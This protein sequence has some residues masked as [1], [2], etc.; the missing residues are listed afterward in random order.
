MKLVNWKPNNNIFDMLDSFDGYF[1]HIVDSSYDY[2]NQNVLINQNDKSY[3]INIEVPGYEKSDINIS[4]DDNI[5]CVTGKRNESNNI[6][7]SSDNI[8]RSFHLPDDV[9]TDKIN[10]KSNNGI[11]VIDIPKLKKVKTDIKK[12]QIS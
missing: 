8:N 6:L 9:N 10:A 3:I 1:N 2:Q 7:V 4:L 5:L 11:L 12:I